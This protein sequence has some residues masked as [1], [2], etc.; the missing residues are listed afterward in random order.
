MSTEQVTPLPDVLS[1]GDQVEYNQ[2]NVILSVRDVYVDTTTITV[3]KV[4]VVG[5][6]HTAD[7]SLQVPSPPYIPPDLIPDNAITFNGAF[8]THKGAYLTYTT[9]YN[10]LTNNGDNLTLNGAFLTYTA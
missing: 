9:P 1:D 5:L 7:G 3:D 8:L 4:D 6:I 2:F 10:T